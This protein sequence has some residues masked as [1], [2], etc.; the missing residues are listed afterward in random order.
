MVNR[1]AHPS[2]SRSYLNAF[3]G[4]KLNGDTAA[5]IEYQR[6]NPL[7]PHDQRI[8]VIAEHSVMHPSFPCFV[9][10]SEDGEARVERRLL[11][12]RCALG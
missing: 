1:L 4:E 2:I 9:S 3:N 10:Q 6:A 5:K 8:V 11:L 12:W 7:E